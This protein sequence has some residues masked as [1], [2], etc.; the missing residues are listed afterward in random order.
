M[1]KSADAQGENVRSGV[2]PA[3]AQHE[4]PIQVDAV[5]PVGALAGSVISLVSQEKARGTTSGSTLLT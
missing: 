2:V 5:D 1:R 4:L 3:K